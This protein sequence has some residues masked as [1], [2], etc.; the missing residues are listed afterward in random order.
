MCNQPAPTAFL[1]IHPPRRLWPSVPMFYSQS[2][3][4]ATPQ[5]AQAVSV[6]RQVTLAT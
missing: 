1:A 6:P 4:G 2:L 5:P 3:L